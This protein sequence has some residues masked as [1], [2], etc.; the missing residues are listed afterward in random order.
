MFILDT[1]ISQLQTSFIL[2][3]PKTGNGYIDLLLYPILIGMMGTVLR[4]LQYKLMPLYYLILDMIRNGYT[5]NTAYLEYEGSIVYNPYRTKINFDLGMSSWF[6]YIF[7]HLDEIHGL[8]SMRRIS[9]DEEL[10][11][12]VTPKIFEEFFLSQDTPITLPNGLKI[13]PFTD[14]KSTYKDD[15]DGSDSKGPKMLCYRIHVLSSSEATSD[16][17]MQKLIREYN[18]VRQ[19]YLDYKQEQINS[20]KQYVYMF[21]EKKENR[22]VFNRYSVDSEPKTFNH[23]WFDGKDEFVKQL[24][25]FSKN[26]EAFR[27]RGKPYRKTILVYGDP[28]CGKTSLLMS[29]LNEMKCQKSQYKRQLIHLKLDKLSRID[30]MNI[31]FKEEL[32]VD[33]AFDGVVKIPFDRRIYYIEEMDSYKMTHQRSDKSEQDTCDKDDTSS[34][35]SFV[36]NIS[37]VLEVKKTAVNTDQALAKLFTPKPETDTNKLTIGD[38]LE[39]LDGIPSM[40][41]GEILFMTTN[42]IDKIDSAI[43]RPGRIN[44]LLHFKKSSKENT[45]HILEKNFG[46]VLTKKQKARI[47]HRKWTPAKIDALYEEDNNLDTLL[48]K[49][50]K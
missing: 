49:L 39:S 20:D 3:L 35:D 40:K 13:H 26:K 42:Y 50:E 4:Y 29:L 25:Y 10:V 23:I 48:K 41:N 7:S 8:K 12:K 18:I 21:R 30:L 37:D 22:V 16:L 11:L 27:S 45:I 44:H 14:N 9:H 31:F 34:E 46:Y 47:P 6:Y 1:I 17:N 5:K 38:L 28:G 43:K 19:D 15:L 33:G 32:V 36:K 24:Q 2:N